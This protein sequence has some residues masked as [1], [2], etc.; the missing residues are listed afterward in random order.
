MEVAGIATW[1]WT[2]LAESGKWSFDQNATLSVHIH[3]ARA[4]V[5]TRVDCNFQLMLKTLEVENYEPRRA[6]ECHQVKTLDPVKHK[7]LLCSFGI[8]SPC[9]VLEQ[10]S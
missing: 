5:Q 2:K 6:T 9:S 8:T 3:T 1:V 4:H 10:N 7:D